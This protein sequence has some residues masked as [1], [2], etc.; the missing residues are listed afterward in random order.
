MESKYAA[1][2]GVDVIG[3]CSQGI[4]NEKILQECVRM[5]QRYNEIRTT[6]PWG[7]EGHFQGAQQS[8]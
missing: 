4:G 7:S 1:G 5:L 6:L 3:T 8:V 2:A